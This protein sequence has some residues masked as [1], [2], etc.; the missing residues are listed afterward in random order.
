MAS[1][2]AQLF[3]E[4]MVGDSVR[5]PHEYATVEVTDGSGKLLAHATS[6]CLVMDNRSST[7]TA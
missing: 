2:P 3:G 1:T 6:S 7:S 4:N 5:R